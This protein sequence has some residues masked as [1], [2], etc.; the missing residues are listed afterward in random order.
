MLHTLRVRDDYVKLIRAGGELGV[1][2][3]IH[4]AAG[5][6][7]YGSRPDQAVYHGYV[8]GDVSAEVGVDEEPMAVCL[9]AVHEVVLLAFVVEGAEESYARVPLA[10]L[11]SASVVWP[12]FGPRHSVMICI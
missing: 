5:P 3:E 11:Q 1:L 12:A 7:A 10:L 9:P 8:A 4:R 6:L 2:E